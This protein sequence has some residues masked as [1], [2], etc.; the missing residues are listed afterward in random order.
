MIMAAKYLLMTNPRPTAVEIRE[1]LS[2]NLCRCAGYSR[3]VAAVQ[4]AAKA[5]E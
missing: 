3:I 2:G 4:A 1:G 5:A